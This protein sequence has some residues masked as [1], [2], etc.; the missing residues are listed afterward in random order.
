LNCT[1]KIHRE[2]RRQSLLFAFSFE[3]ILKYTVSMTRCQEKMC[4]W[5]DCRDR[6]YVKR[7]KE[8]ITGK[9]HVHCYMQIM[10][11][12]RIRPLLIQTINVLKNNEKKDVR[13]YPPVIVSSLLAQVGAS[14]N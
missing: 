11:K 9:V 8:K 10:A 5:F 14:P 1:T 4:R 7:Q 3:K 2:S 12:G 13:L 6:V